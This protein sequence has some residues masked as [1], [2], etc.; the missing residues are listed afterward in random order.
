MPEGFSEV[1]GENS[2][3]PKPEKPKKDPWKIIAII[4]IIGLL[5]VGGYFGYEYLFRRAFEEG[6]KEG[7]KEGVSYGATAV[8][9][10]QV[11][12]QEIFWIK[13]GTIVNYPLVNFCGGG[14]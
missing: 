10:E 9:E 11:K 14:N 5:G 13:N 7:Y 3:R 1:V 6:Y 12:N 4:L 2:V 8:V